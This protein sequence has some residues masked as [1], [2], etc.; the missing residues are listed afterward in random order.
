MS[1]PFRPTPASGTAPVPPPTAPSGKTTPASRRGASAAAFARA[2]AS[3]ALTAIAAAA[4][5]WPASQ[6]FKNGVGA[7][8]LGLGEAFTGLADDASALY[9]NPA[10]LTQ[11]KGNAFHLSVGHEYLESLSALNGSGAS[12]GVAEA[13]RIQAATLILRPQKAWAFAFGYQNPLS[14]ADPFRYTHEDGE[15]RYQAGGSLGQF[16]LAAAYRA[17]K[18][19]RLDLAVSALGGEGQLEIEDAGQTERYLQEF[20]GFHIE[21]SFLLRLS[22]QVR[23]GGSVILAERLRLRDTYQAEDE[24]P[25]VSEFTLR[26]P[27]QA[28]LGLAF[29]SDLTTLA[30]DWHGDLWS[31]ASFGGPGVTF[32]ESDPGLRN[33]HL[34]A[35]GVEQRLAP[36]GVALRGGY[37][38]EK[39]DGPVARPGLL[40]PHRFHAGLGLPAGSRL[41]VDLAYQYRHAEEALSSRGDGTPD[42][43]VDRYGHQ[44]VGGVTWKF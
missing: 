23:L 27:A 33:R 35:I 28:R 36:G 21:P 3:L 29:E 15:Y 10:G 6:G 26:N 12:K 40:S 37:A 18:E 5:E 41:S 17:S 30:L 42:L 4:A 44:M 11:L 39:A 8:P 2:S 43:V 25:L 16:R 34:F 19:V 7:R 38:F 31:A 20:T 14:Y 1:H 13:T 24:R 9:Y 22:P 32:L